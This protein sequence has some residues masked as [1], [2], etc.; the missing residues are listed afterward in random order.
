MYSKNY[1]TTQTTLRII[2]DTNGSYGI[3]GRDIHVFILKDLQQIEP[4][5]HK[6]QEPEV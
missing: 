5:A 6:L 3:Y 2:K 1:Y 4:V